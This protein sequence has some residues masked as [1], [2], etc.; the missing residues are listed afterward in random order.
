MY[1]D[2]TV[3]RLKAGKG[4]LCRLYEPIQ[5]ENILFKGIISI[6][7]IQNSEVVISRV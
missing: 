3:T 7:T 5:G 4:S 2:Q 1:V 6:E